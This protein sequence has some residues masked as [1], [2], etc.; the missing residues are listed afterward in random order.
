MLDALVRKAR[1][2]AGDPVLR[3]WLF[4]RLCGRAAGEP[5]F[6][7]HRPTYLDGM[8]PLRREIPQARFPEIA[9]GPPEAEIALP[10]PGQTV[11]L[12]PGEEAELFR[13][14]FADP[15]TLIAVHRFA[16]LPLLGDGV[17]PAWVALLWRAW[18]DRYGSPDGG[19]AW[20]P[21]TAAE[22]AINLV[23]FARRSGL[24]R[25]GVETLDLLARHAPAIA[26]RLEYFGEHHTSNHLANDGRGL[27]LL[28]LALGLPGCADMGGRILVR[29]A[30]RIFAPSGVMREGSSHYHLL[31]VRVYASAWLA[32]RAHGRS[33]AAAL[34]GV[35]RK[36]V[37]VIPRLALPGG[38]P[39]IGDISPDCPV[40]Y[41]M[42]LAPGGTRGV[43]PRQ[44]YA[45]D[46]PAAPGGTQGVS[47]GGGPDGW[48]GGLDPGDR[49][50]MLALSE[51]CAPVAVG[52]LAADGWLRA[53]FGRWSGLWHA[54]PE[55]WSRMPGHGHQ[56]CGGF[57]VHYGAEPL[58]RDLGRGTY[59][60]TG[61]AAHD[62]SAL[63]H[64]TVVVD[65]ADPY[66][67][68]RP[69]YDPAFRRR[70]GGPPPVLSRRGNQVTLT[71]DGFARLSGGGAVHRSWTFSR[72]GFRIRD[73]I[74]GGG[75]HR[76]TRRLHTT[77]A[78]EP[79]TD[80]VVI[81]GETA[82]FR[83]VGDG[84]VTR[85]PATLW[86]AY[87][88]GEAATAIDVTIDAELPLDCEFTVEV[89]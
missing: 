47:P 46:A 65:G 53:D 30:Q 15:E 1:Q 71:H 84:P 73:R 3:D 32:A 48:V 10:L 67:P 72:S 74:E 34:E 81:R 70:I 89:L 26:G 36:A 55:G 28:G 42:G 35:V 19:V 17:E 88:T 57:E 75:R 79:T 33:E 82:Q 87:G 51:S 27:Y 44:R 63:A 24:P 80:G 39:L 78:I 45:G 43:S 83:L 69:Y 31:L 66:P 5:R 21:Y 22:R 20:H 58:F 56:D 2:V 12:R 68:N 23:E 7:P 25:P 40:G 6:E 8:L 37:A 52:A 85:E 64:N 9:D 49:E 38:L 76:V 41:L 29:E 62:R 18:Q 59:A 86:S 14:S 61:E 77:L 50:A 11:R 60:E 16:W 13:R 4:D 54:A